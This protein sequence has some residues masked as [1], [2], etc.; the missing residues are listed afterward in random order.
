MRS[1][2]QLQLRLGGIPPGEVL[3]ARDGTEYPL[4]KDEMAWQLNFFETMSG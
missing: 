3:N 1:A 2:M 4:S